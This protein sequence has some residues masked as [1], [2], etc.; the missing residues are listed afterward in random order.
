[1]SAP[2]SQR[3][4][5]VQQ[6]DAAG[7]PVRPLSTIAQFSFPTTALG[8]DETLDVVGARADQ[9]LLVYGGYSPDTDWDVMAAVR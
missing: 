1:M 3:S 4:V 2:E 7:M 8:A 6:F 5:S 9:Y